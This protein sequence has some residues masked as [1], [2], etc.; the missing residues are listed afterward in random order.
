MDYQHVLVFLSGATAL[1]IVGH[2]VNT[3]PTPAN[4]YGAWFIGILQY[5]VGQR[6]QALNTMN[7]QSTIT[8]PVSRTMAKEIE[9]AGIVNSDGS[10]RER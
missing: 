4:K 5:A 2:A 10:A 3:F 6:Q 9:A 7:G 8:A 1:G